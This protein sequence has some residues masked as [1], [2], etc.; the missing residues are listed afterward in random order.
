MLTNE[1]WLKIHKK[2][3][4][5]MYAVAH[6]IGGDKIANDFDDSNQELAITA[7]DACDAFSRKTGEDFDTYFGTIPFDK[8]IKTCLWNKKNNV[9]N[10]IKKKYEIRRC[11]SLS[12]N[13]EMFSTETGATYGSTTLETD[14]TPVSAFDD[15]DLD[16]TAQAIA[17]AV[18]SDMRIIKP[19]GSLNISKLSRIT[20]KPKNEVR[21]AIE[22]MKYDLRDY[23][24]ETN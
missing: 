22:K 2:Y 15:A 20:N 18:I 7:M 4:R 19:D 24:N 8:Y 6:R 21:I 1:Q 16:S 13:P 9:G 14:P 23:N 5:L 3:K 11:V 10:K 17:D 12:S